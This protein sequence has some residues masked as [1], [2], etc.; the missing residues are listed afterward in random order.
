MG[1]SLSR[2]LMGRLCP[3][4][5]QKVESETEK[6]THSR[7]Y[8]LACFP[9]KSLVKATQTLNEYSSICL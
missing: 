7:K 1:V 9:G 4:L 3:L 2:S 6:G 8:T 5:D